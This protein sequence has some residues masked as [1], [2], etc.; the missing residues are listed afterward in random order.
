MKKIVIVFVALLLVGLTGCSNNSGSGSKDEVQTLVISTWG[1]SEDVLWEDVYGPFEEEYNVKIVLDTGTTA[2]RYAKL[3][4]NP[5]SGIDV[6]ELSQKSAAD[7]Y[8]D[9]LF[10]QLDY[11]KIPNA[12]YLIPGAQAISDLG[13]GPAYTVNSIGIVYD[14]EAVGF[15]IT[16]WSDLW[17]SELAN[18]I[19]V[20]DITTTFGPAFVVMAGDVAGVDYTQDNGAA[21]FEKLAELKPNIVKTYS[22][23]SDLAIMFASGEIKVAIVGDF[24]YP[25][26][27]EAAPQIEYFVP[28]SGT[29]ANFNTIDINVNSENKELAYAYINWRL[30]QDHQLKTAESLNEA[31][32]NSL[33]V[34]TEELQENKTYG[35]V[36]E[37]AKALDY[38]IINPLMEDWIDQFNRLFNQ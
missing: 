24:G 12:E 32:V 35:D 31:P 28:A 14:R 19:A 20:P 6:I 23:S 17:N 10:E 9:G 15:E 36:A 26:I 2:E 13:Y 3:K 16:D 7:G 30:E 38:S 8:A 4:N 11:S 18:S 37:R 33:V 1:L 5:N 22:K 34:L 27:K 25:V 21:A 29:Y